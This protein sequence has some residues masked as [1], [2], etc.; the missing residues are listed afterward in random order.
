ML[1]KPVKKF[2]IVNFALIRGVFQLLTSLNVTIKTFSHILNIKIIA[3]YGFLLYCISVVNKV[4]DF[5]GILEG[6]G[7]GKDA[8]S[9]AI[10][11]IF[12]LEEFYCA[13]ELV[14]IYNYILLNI[15]EPEILSAVIK[16]SDKYRFD[17]TLSILVDLLLLKNFECEDIDEFI[18]TR[19]LCAKAISNYKDT[20][21]VGALLYCLN[22]K[23][24]NYKIRLACADAL[25]RIGDKFAVT[26]LINVVK[27]EDEKSVYVKESATFALGLLGDESAIDPLIA[28]MEAKQGLWDKFSFLKERIVEAL[29]KLNINNR[30][31]LKVLKESLMDSSSMVRINAIE[32]LMNSEFEEAYDLIRT[33]LKDEDNEVQRNALIAMY[34]MKGRDILDEVISLPGYSEFLKEEAKS[35][36]EEYEDEAG[37]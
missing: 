4:L 25:G 29:G 3:N 17:S 30:R 14:E 23:E 22:N 10:A 11:N 12:G 9:V 1:N 34:N 28:I 32:A 19:V 13:Q 37:E 6:C 27:D 16:L 8:P 26:P 20:S 33:A 36:I 18:N 21:T 2:F 7:V 24:E 31:V 35:I 15:K 5:S